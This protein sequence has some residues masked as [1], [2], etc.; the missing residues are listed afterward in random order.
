MTIWEKKPKE[1]TKSPRQR[2]GAAGHAR[3][4]W[5]MQQQP[6]LQGAQKIQITIYPTGKP[7]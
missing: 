2:V 4:A 7:L 1:E 3:H 5:A 6:R